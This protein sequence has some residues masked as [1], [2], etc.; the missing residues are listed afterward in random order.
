MKKQLFIVCFALFSALLMA[1]G[2]SAYWEILQITNNELDDVDPDINNSGQ[3]AWLMHLD[4]N[5]HNKIYL[6]N[7]S[8]T[9]CISENHNS[10]NDFPVINDNGH[11]VWKIILRIMIL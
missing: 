7:G 8:E 11:V 4:E 9:L 2:V 3:A 6:Y 5:D 1:H 10:Q